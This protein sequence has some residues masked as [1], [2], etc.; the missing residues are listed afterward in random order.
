MH[1]SL[2]PPAR[3]CLLSAAMTAHRTGACHH[4]LLPLLLSLALAARATVLRV[5]EEWPLIQT[6][7]DSCAHGDTVLVAPGH[8]HERLVV[9]HKAVTLGSRTL[10]TG[11]TLFIPQT[12]LDGDSLGTVL[13]VTGGSLD[14]F[15][16]DGFTVQRGRSTVDYLGAGGIR[17]ADSTV[18]TLRNLHFNEN[19]GYN[20]ADLSVLA[21]SAYVQHVRTNNS[22]SLSS[23]GRCID[24][25]AM[26][27]MNFRDYRQVSNH[28][29][30]CYLR[31]VDSLYIDGFNAID[32]QVEDDALL[33]AVAGPVMVGD[34]YIGGIVCKNINVTDCELLN[35]GAIF[36][37]AGGTLKASRISVEGCNSNNPEA[38][39]SLIGIGAGPGILFADS[40][41]VINNRIRG[42]AHQMIYFGTTADN[43]HWNKIGHIRNLI[44]EN[45]ILGDSTW[46]EDYNPVLLTT[47]DCDIQNGSVS[48]NSVILAEHYDNF[49]QVNG[50][51]RIVDFVCHFIDVIDSIR[52]DNID[53]IG[54]EIIDLNNYS[55]ET[56]I[57]HPHAIF[58]IQQSWCQ[59]PSYSDLRFVMNRISNTPPEVSWLWPFYVESVNG[60]MRI[61]NHYFSDPGWNWV[62]RLENLVFRDN[63]EGGLTVFNDMN[64]EIRN[65][66]MF[67]VAREA[68]HIEAVSFTVDNLLIDGFR[69]VRP[70]PF[71]STQI[72]IDARSE[73]AG[74]IRNFTIR[75]CVTACLTRSGA[76]E[77]GDSLTPL[78]DYK[79]GIFDENTFSTFEYLLSSRFGRFSYCLLPTDPSYGNDN[80]IGFAPEW[81]EELGAP[82]LAATSS[83]IDAGTPDVAQ[84]DREDP[85]NP[86]FA[87]WPSQG[88]LRNDIGFTGGPHAALLDTNWVGV[89]P[90][91]PHVTPRD[92]S[93]G[94]PWPN[95]FNPVT[96]I[97]VLLSRPSLARLVVHNV[98]GQQ[99]AVL[100][101]GLLPAG[102]H[103]FRWDAHRQASG[104]YFLT[105]TVDL[106]RTQTRAVTLLR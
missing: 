5:P 21:N 47:K 91:E 19:K 65:V 30:G 96:Q 62:T 48:R 2:V 55:S 14:T 11:D 41:S 97:P 43:P 39:H 34:Y 53:F 83:L 87:L 25:Y 103:V 68:L 42:Q 77:E 1:N 95:P 44:V 20:H 16:M 27:Y 81:H 7:L 78:I 35:S 54:N 15:T 38:P 70:R 32:C 4:L 18:V 88:G 106:E 61:V 29:G 37:A 66:Q 12:I 56:R 85:T 31:A 28:L 40:I 105:L 69:R 24:I 98:Q 75:N 99:V 72:P 57:M 33:F 8:Y 100:H 71:Q 60:V 10:L 74:Q 9:N 86:G 90:W 36:V 76:I 92:F 102:R 17:I 80:L 94:A 59:Y 63:D 46:V 22:S 79:N 89:T 84:N 45:N 93:M 51:A 64:V 52:F 50:G 101:D 49:D 58:Y 26:R 73:S 104:L 23:G 3:Q 67:N 82:Y 6:A 13:T